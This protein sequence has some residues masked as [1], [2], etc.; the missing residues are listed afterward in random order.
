MHILKNIFYAV[1]IHTYGHNI[2]PKGEVRKD[3][4]A[5]TKRYIFCDYDVKCLII[6]IA[7]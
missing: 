7:L 1:K 3:A 4:N 5:T 2:A 6:K